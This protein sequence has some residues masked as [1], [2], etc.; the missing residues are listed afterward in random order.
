LISKLRRHKT[1]FLIAKGSNCIAGIIFGL[2]FFM[3]YLKIYLFL[4]ISDI[5]VF[6]GIIG[7]GITISLTCS[8]LMED[9]LK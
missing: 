2:F 7:L 6:L 9:Q 3:L 8:L 5:C 4:K 1:P